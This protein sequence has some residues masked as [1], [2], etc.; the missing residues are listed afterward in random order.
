MSRGRSPNERAPTSQYQQDQR[1]KT[2]LRY[3]FISGS[4]IL[5]I[6]FLPFIPELSL[7]NT[8]LPG[9]LQIAQVNRAP[10]EKDEESR[11]DDGTR[12]QKD[13]NFYYAMVRVVVV[14]LEGA[15]YNTDDDI[16]AKRV[17]HI[18]KF[19]S[20]K[21]RYL[22][23]THGD[24]KSICGAKDRL[25][26]HRRSDTIHDGGWTKRKCESVD[27]K[28]GRETFLTIGPINQSHCYKHSDPT[29]CHCIY[30]KE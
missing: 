23:V 27:A 9:P 22:R 15:C 29:E 12:G 11:N 19:D 1:R 5:V 7:R 18:F 30:V 24:F 3:A 20:L 8:L 16:H 21:T 26:P 17:S 25:M 28:C 6:S 10:R 14:V 2:C 4:I 13:V